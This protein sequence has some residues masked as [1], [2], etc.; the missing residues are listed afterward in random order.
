MV[1]SDLLIITI[2]FLSLFTLMVDF[3]LARLR[4]DRFGEVATRTLRIKRAN[5]S[6]SN[7][8]YRK[9]AW[10]ISIAE[11]EQSLHT[12]LKNQ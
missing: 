6:L 9:P 5:S 3:R 4:Y 1:K 11:L 10:P 2:S 8:L 12:E 7:C